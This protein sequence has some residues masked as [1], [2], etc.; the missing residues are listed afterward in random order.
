[1]VLGWWN[2]IFFAL[3]SQGCAWK[4]GPDE[5]MN[6]GPTLVYFQ[7]LLETSSNVEQRLVATGKEAFRDGRAWSYS[8]NST[9]CI[10][11]CIS[12]LTTNEP[13]RSHSPAA[14]QPA[15]QLVPASSGQDDRLPF[16]PMRHVGDVHGILLIRAWTTQ[17]QSC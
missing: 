7:L 5:R 8:S 17:W 11:L 16:S 3:E 10:T 12:R 9:R 13:L 1:M 14:S 4:Q 2:N 6:V 15:S